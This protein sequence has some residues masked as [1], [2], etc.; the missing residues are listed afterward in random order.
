MNTQTSP[1]KVTLTYRQIQVLSLMGQGYTNAEIAK[2]LNITR[3]TVKAH[4]CAIYEI[5]G[6]ASRVQAVVKALRLH[7]V[8]LQDL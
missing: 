6:T 5:L 3:H 8:N 1:E 7:L 2:I 4:A